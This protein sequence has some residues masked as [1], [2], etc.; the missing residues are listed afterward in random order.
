MQLLK[1]QLWFISMKPPGWFW[2]VVFQ[3]NSY[4]KNM[5]LGVPRLLI[6]CLAYFV[7]VCV[8]SECSKTFFTSPGR[9]EGD[10]QVAHTSSLSEGNKCE[11]NIEADENEAISLNIS[12]LYGF[13]ELP[14]PE[15]KNGE[16]PLAGSSTSDCL[17]RLELTAVT[18]LGHEN[19]LRTVCRGDLKSW[20]APR[21]LKTD[22]HTIR[23]TYEWAPGERSG[24]TLTYQ[25][26]ISQ[27]KYPWN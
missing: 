23:V 6:V 11:Y 19:V 7:F 5:A 13:D 18:P 27:S 24:F 17:P 9:I 21:T 8:F 2:N 16:K 12:S 3:V 22:A 14:Q 15:S 20:P 25:F 1:Y 26:T 10:S 4:Q